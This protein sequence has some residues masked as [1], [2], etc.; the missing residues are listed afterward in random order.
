MEPR[1]LKKED[2]ATVKDWLRDYLT[3][4]LN[5][6]S[7]VY[8]VAPQNDLETLVKEEWAELLEAASKE[9]MF[10]GVVGDSPAGIVY[11]RT[12]H[13]KYLGIK[14]GVIAWIYVAPEARGQT[15]SAQLMNAASA[16]MKARAVRGREVF[17]T[18]ENVS[19]VGLYERHG[20]SVI[21]HRMLAEG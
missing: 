2:E 1:Q 9:E 3:Q 5:W 7:E 15:I 10:V 19:A 4:H 12:R 8:G 21:D 6:W 13:D 14:I 11:A 17:V 18:A 20:Y 16:W